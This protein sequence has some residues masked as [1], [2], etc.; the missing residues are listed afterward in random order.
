LVERVES[1]VNRIVKEMGPIDMSQSTLNVRVEV[2][3]DPAP[4]DA[5]PLGQDKPA[6][7]DPGEH[8]SVAGV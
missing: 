5:R 4:P 8:G 3:V 7:H 6:K 2:T 1:E